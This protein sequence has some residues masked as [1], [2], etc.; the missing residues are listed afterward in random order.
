MSYQLS[1]NILATVTYY[2]VM[3]MPLTAFEIW[4]H[5]IVY[6]RDNDLCAVPSKLSDIVTLLDSDF[7]RE[8]LGRKDGFFFLKGRDRLVEERIRLEKISVRKLKRERRLARLLAFVPYVR[9]VGAT[10]SLSMKH[11]SKKSDWDMFVVLKSGRI[12]TGRTVLTGFLHMIGKRRHGNKVTDRACLNYFVT[13]DHLEIGIKDLYSAHEYRFLIP[14]INFPLYQ[15]FE[16]KNRWIREYQPNFAPTLIASTW[17]VPSSRLAV[18]VQRFLEQVL[19]FFPVE[20]WLGS[21]QK[22]KIRRN[23]KT[24][25]EGSHIEAHDRA[26]IFL[27]KP[28]GP[29]VFEQFK[30]RLGA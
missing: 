3:D 28:R 27:P 16:R 6:E 19:D 11:G 9:M 12:W 26:L 14:L 8:K 21:W 23:P 20:D 2:D 29:R 17:S 5:L 13:D 25:L 7:C 22:E 18:S 1:K 4:R 30:A 24:A 10:G 15:T